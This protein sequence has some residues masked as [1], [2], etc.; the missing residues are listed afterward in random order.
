MA[1]LTKVIRR[2][3][4]RK[5]ARGPLP[6]NGGRPKKGEEDKTLRATRPWEA[7]GISMR[8]WYR[9]QKASAQT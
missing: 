1:K 3:S 7:E 6:G 9:R 8:T 5:G 4:R 2:V